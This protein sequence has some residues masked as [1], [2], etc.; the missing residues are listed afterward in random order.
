M[1]KAENRRTPERIVQI[2]NTES[3]KQNT[4]RLS[5]ITAI[6]NETTFS[7]TLAV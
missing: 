7:P 1:T 5:A 4:R 2:L 3:T 6:D